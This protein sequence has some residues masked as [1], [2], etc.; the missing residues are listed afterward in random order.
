MITERAYAKINLFLD[1]VGIREN[2]YHD[3]VSVM[4]TVDWYDSIRIEKNVS[5]EIK[6][7]ES[8][9][10]LPSNEQNIAYRAA[11]RFLDHIGSCDGVDIVLEKHIPIAAGMAGGSADAAAVLRGCNHL[12]EDPLNMDE[13]CSLG[14]TLGADIPFCLVGGT[15]IVK[16]IGEHLEDI[17]SLQD[18]YVVCA[19]MGDGVS[20]PEGYRMLDEK[21]N[22]FLGYMWH[23]E[24]FQQLLDGL[25]DGDVRMCCK[26]M[27]NV[28]ESVIP[29]MRPNVQKLK[30][31]FSEH[32]GVAMMSGSG[33]SV[34]GIFMNAIMA[35]KACEK[36]RLMGAQARVCRPI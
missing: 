14:A 34:F 12:W 27:Y 7:L 8:S 17:V 10:Q 15:K 30:D 9:G 35:E 6:I 13:L 25:K 21:H 31:T 32:G 22:A 19:K 16:G 4:Q 29:E 33:P 18:C 28:F 23:D 11:K 3:I 1:I 36:V 24:T 20:T 2:G 5:G 26:G